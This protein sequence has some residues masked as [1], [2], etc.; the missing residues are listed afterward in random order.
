MPE[1][2]PLDR[3]AADAPLRG[4]TVVEVAGELTGY[5]GKLLADL[6]AEVVL[7]ERSPAETE[8]FNPHA[9]FLDHGKTRVLDPGSEE[10]ERL[11][12][13]ADVVLQSAGSGETCPPELEPDVVRERNPRAVHT[14][15]T[16][17]GLS[18]PRADDASTDLIRLAAGGLLWLGGYPD[19]EPV[20]AWGDQ[21]AI[22]TGIYGAVAALLALVARENTGKG[23][24]IEVSAQEVVIQALETS[25]AEY[26]L[27]GKVRGRL[28]A[29]PREAGTGVY[30]CADGFVSMVAGRLGTATAWKH[31][32][33]WLQE[34][35]VPGAERLSEPGWDTLEHRQLPASIAQFSEVF[36][37]FSADRGKDALYREGQR[38][39]IAI[40]P[41]ND[42]AEVLRD[43][44]LEARS[45][46]AD[47]VDPETGTAVRL[48]APP[49]RL[50]PHTA[51]PR[52]RREP[53]PSS[54]P[55]AL[56]DRA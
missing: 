11:L 22:A 33:A 7:V 12:E 45:F 5:A 16:P 29:E 23:D 31:L 25:L 49:F 8:G 21:S 15:L 32:V 42:V 43:A 56:P 1:L 44:Q 50:S 20:A 55:T 38:R 47:A 10:L 40:A 27:A 26:E 4:T 18:G 35:G 51:S 52:A 36:E 46:F 14:I 30:P 54:A 53:A 37:R 28:G 2:R 9:F 13:R 19:A 39:G 3:G 34:S 48:P 41:V 6:G 24:T 17:F